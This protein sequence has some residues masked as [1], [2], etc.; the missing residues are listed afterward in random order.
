[1]LA[2]GAVLSGQGAGMP[3]LPGEFHKPTQP[4]EAA[5][6]IRRTGG[7]PLMPSPRLPDD[8]LAGAPAAIDLTGLNLDYVRRAPDGRLQIGAMTPLQTLVEA[9]L[10]QDVAGGLLVR[11]A[12]LAAGSAMRHLATVG[13]AL[14]APK[15][16]PEV[17]L[18]LLVLD[19]S[20]LL[21]GASARREAPL[22]EF[23]PGADL[24]LEV[25]LTAARR[26]ALERV[27]RTPRDEAIVAVAAVMQIEHGVCRHVRL[28]VGGAG[29]RPALVR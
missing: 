15:G 22:S 25:S 9:P 8:Y 21:Q 26:G 16:P 19:A 4:D 14:T 24:L 7:W 2:S 23:A 12:Q 20:L 1:M 6:L 3:N 13:G 27:A 28:A 17:A 18:A 10:A 11:A 5:Q 29:P